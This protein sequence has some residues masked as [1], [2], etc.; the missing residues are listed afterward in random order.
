ML[1]RWLNGVGEGAG[2]R[3][4]I[5]RRWEENPWF[6]AFLVAGGGAF[7]GDVWPATGVSESSPVRSINCFRLVVSDLSKGPFLFF[8][9]SFK[10]WFWLSKTCGLAALAFLEDLFV[11]S[12]ETGGPFF[13]ACFF[14]VAG[15][16]CIV[17]MERIAC[18]RRQETRRVADAVQF[19]LAR[20]LKECKSWKR[21][22]DDEE[23]DV[24]S[25]G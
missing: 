20:A 15:F 23:W 6:E 2:A 25:D 22:D 14:G 11:A 18:N 5:S 10:A 1:F 9:D 13:D 17:D 24:G 4:G 7:A 19:L 3:C 16:F 12:L 21:V 8:V